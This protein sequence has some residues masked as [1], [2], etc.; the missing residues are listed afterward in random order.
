MDIVH[1]MRAPDC[2]ASVNLFL[3]AGL[4]GLI[5]VTAV[6]FSFVGESAAQEDAGCSTTAIARQRSSSPVGCISGP[7]SGGGDAPLLDNSNATIDDGRGNVSGNGVGWMYDSTVTGGEGF[8]SVG[9]QSYRYGSVTVPFGVP[10]VESFLAAIRTPDETIYEYVKIPSSSQT[11]SI[12]A[13]RVNSILHPGGGYSLVDYDGRSNVKKITRYNTGG[14]QTITQE[15][16]YPTQ[17]T[18]QQTCNKPTWVKD[19]EGNQTDYEYSPVH[20]MV[21]SVTGPADDN[22]VRPQTRYGYTQLYPRIKNAGGALVNGPDP[23]W[24][25]T[26]EKFCKTSTGSVNGCAAGT[27]DE[28]ATTYEYGP[29]NQPNNLWDQPNNLWL[30]GVVVTADGQS[31]RSCIYYD[32]FGHVIAETAPKADL[33]SCS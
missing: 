6:A 8:R 20:G 11:H 27:S 7:P 4:L 30:R 19:G 5:G 22:G 3:P 12:S 24:L 29:A 17:C 10:V 28:V 15:A 13:E 1:N 2:R 18:D 23:I 9:T 25:L 16:S 21:T 31:L 32:A 26:S 14:T 33:V